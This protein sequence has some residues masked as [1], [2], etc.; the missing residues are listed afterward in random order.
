MAA[1]AQQG[2]NAAQKGDP[3]LDTA[4]WSD[5]AGGPG[6]LRVEYILPGA[7]FTVMASGVLWPFV[8]TSLGRDVADASR[9]RLVWVD[10]CAKGDTECL[11][12]VGRPKPG[13]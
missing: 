10:L 1:A 4:D 8:D 6:N 9:H 12:R 7:A 2:V 13:E 5:D 11:A 3:A